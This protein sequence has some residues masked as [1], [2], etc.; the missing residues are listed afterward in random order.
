MAF[1]AAPAFI[2]IS[3]RLALF[4]GPLGPFESRSSALVIGLSFNSPSCSLSAVAPMLSRP[5][6]RWSEILAELVRGVLVGHAE[7]FD[8]S[9]AVLP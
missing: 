1:A 7:G 3:V 9:S 2:V 5:A 8:D 4:L 6:L